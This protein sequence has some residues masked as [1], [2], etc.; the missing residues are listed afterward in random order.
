MSVE[1]LL[2]LLLAVYGKFKKLAKCKG[3]KQKH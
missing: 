2:S 1:T 3:I